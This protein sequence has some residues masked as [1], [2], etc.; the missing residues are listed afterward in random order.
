[1][2]RKVFD[3]NKLQIFG[4]RVERKKRLYNADTG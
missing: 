3:W 4:K 2:Q 1:M